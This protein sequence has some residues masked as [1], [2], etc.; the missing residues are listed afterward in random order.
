MNKVSFV[1]FFLICLISLNC[2]TRNREITISIENSSHIQ[3]KI[4]VESLL[5]GHS[6]DKRDVVKGENTVHLESFK[7]PIS[8]NQDS[9]SI[10]FKVL[11]TQY[12]AKCNFS[13]KQITNATW[14]HVNLNEIVFKK[15]YEYNGRILEKD[16]II[17]KFFYCELVN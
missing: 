14:I 2:K 11:G 4:V 8:N 12:N 1:R 16:T 6:I 10:A 9:I 5:N 3:K 15:G 7:I 13:P 17:E